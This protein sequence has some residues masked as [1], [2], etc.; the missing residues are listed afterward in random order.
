[1]LAFTLALNLAANIWR[2]AHLDR[3]GFGVQHEDTLHQQ[4]FSEYVL[5][6]YL[7]SLGIVR[8]CEEESVDW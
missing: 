7:S 3:L 8:W 1:M 5:S 6:Y 4:A 2:A